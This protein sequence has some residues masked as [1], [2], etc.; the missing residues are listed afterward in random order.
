M[1]AL[2][3]LLAS[4][5]TPASRIT[6]EVTESAALAYPER[7]AD[8]LRR[9]TA[10]G[11]RVSIDD[12]GAGQS[13]LSY[14]RNLPASEI[15]IDKSF[16]TDLASSRSDQAMVRST[17]DLAHQLGLEVVAEGVETREVLDLLR[18]YGCDGAQGWLIG[19]PTPAPTTR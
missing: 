10:L 7:A 13:T 14:L 6:G 2:A 15:K 18:S 12:Y 16:V 8:A 1:R 5:S 19:R 17:I 4:A 11:V 3:A 9:L